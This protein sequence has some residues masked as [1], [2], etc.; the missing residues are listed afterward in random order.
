MSDFSVRVVNNITKEYPDM[1]KVIVYKEPQ[2][3][4]KSGAVKRVK[5]VVADDLYTPDVTSL[6]RTKQLIKDIIECNDFEVF[7]TFTFDPQKV[8]SFSLPACWRVMSTW[9]HHQRD[10]ARDRGIEFKYLVVPEQHKSGRWHFHALLVGFAGRMRPARLITDTGRP[11]YNITAFRSGFTT[12]C[13]IDSKEAVAEYVSKYI[14]KDFV[15][16]FNQRRFFASRT[17]IRPKCTTNSSIF[18]NTPPLFRR[19]VADTG[20]ADIFLLPSY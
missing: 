7:A 9:L 15:R 10:N 20:G 6:W 8:D 17:L 19:H 1:I 14:T 13:Y 16:K 11:V 2:Y 4:I 3:Y 12:A 18:R 5:E